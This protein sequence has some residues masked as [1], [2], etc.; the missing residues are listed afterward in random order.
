MPL[1]LNVPEFWI[2][3][4]CKYASGFE[5]TRILNTPDFWL[6]QGYTGFRICLNNSWLCLKMPDHVEICVNM[7]EYAWICLNLPEWLLLYVLPV[8]TLH[9]TWLGLLE[10]RLTFLMKIKHS[11]FLFKIIF[12]KKITASL[13][14]FIK[15]SFQS[16]IKNLILVKKIVIKKK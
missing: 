9:Y 11:V 10:N 4:G 5:Y 15:E 6:C 14:R 2:Y 16:K 7:P 8:V 1:V 3:Q 13:Y 12:L